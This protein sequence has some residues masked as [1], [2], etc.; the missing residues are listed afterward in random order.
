MKPNIQIN[1]YG[2]RYPVLLEDN[3]TAT[4]LQSLLPLSHRMK[5]LNGNEKYAELTQK[6]PTDIKVPKQINKGDLMLYKDNILVLFYKSF[7]TPYAYTKI[8]TVSN[9]PD[10]GIEDIEVTLKEEK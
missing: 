7:T 10:F 2:K 3:E 1:I 5:E 9:L 6:L 4:K 8:G